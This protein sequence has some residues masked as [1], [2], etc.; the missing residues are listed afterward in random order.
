MELS[1]HVVDFEKCS[2]IKSQILVDF[3]AEWT[4]HA[5]TVEGAVP[6]SAWLVYC[7]EAWGAIGARAAAILTSPSRI[8]LCYAT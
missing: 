1:E 5:F 8:K 7:D 3:V 6:E 2:A 4:E